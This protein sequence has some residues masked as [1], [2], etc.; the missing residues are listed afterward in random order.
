[1]T[2]RTQYGWDLWINSW[3]AALAVGVLVWGLILWCIIAYRRRKTDKGYP[4]QLSYNLPIE[5]FY[6]FV[7]LAM[8]FVL[9]YFT[10]IAQT[11]ILQRSDDPAVVIDVR[12]KQWSWDFNYVKE[13]TYE[14]GTQAQ[15]DGKTG[16]RDRIPTL[17]LPVN[18]TVEL[19]LNARDVIHSF[20]VPAFL[21]KM[22]A[23]PGKTNYMTFTP[24]KEGKFD[25][26]CTELCGEYHSEMLF[27]VEVVSQ[28]EFDQRMQQ[29]R[30]RGQ[31]G[32]IGKEYDRNSELTPNPVS[33]G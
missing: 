11:K 14:T 30:D 2:D 4:R 18:R 9:F 31:S 22:D 13:N 5:I 7:P 32:Q 21:Q 24:Q 29:L 15:L 23:I 17:Y 19:Q 1:M 33:K 10:D 26:K 16:A 6:T 8:V 20:W 12:A 3:I 28:A 25:G 27:N